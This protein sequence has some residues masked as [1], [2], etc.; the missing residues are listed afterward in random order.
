MT[1]HS[2]EYYF[3]YITYRLH[4]DSYAGSRHFMKYATISIVNVSFEIAGPFSERFW[5]TTSTGVAQILK[6]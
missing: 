1:C 2:V 4:A 5:K 3:V 6:G